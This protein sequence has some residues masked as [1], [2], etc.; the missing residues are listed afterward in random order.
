MI[1][2][3]F[4]TIVFG[5]SQTPKDLEW[6][7][8]KVL[9]EKLEDPHLLAVDDKFLYFVTGGHLASLKAGTSGVWKISI[10]GG[11]PIQLFKGYQKDEKTV[12]LPD[13]FVLAIDKEYVYFAAG[14]IYRI[15]KEGGEPEQITAGTPT[16]MV[17]DEENIYWHNFVGE[18]M[19]PT[20]VYSVS[21][22]GGEVKT[23]TDA[24]RVIDIAVD[25]EGFYWAQMDGIYKIG[26]KS[27]EKIRVYKAANGSRIT[28]MIIDKDSILLVENN[29]LF[30]IPKTGG[31]AKIITP[32]INSV[33]KFFVD[34]RNVYFVI[35]EGS[36]GTSLNKVSKSGGEVTKIDSGYFNQ[37]LIGKDKIY[38]SDKARIYELAK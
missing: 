29:Q 28:G 26:K 15:S 1:L 19:P 37:Y 23:L 4:L 30:E 11:Q 25:Q 22:K 18:S 34:E 12:F 36:F 38:I 20:P 6:T 13:T 31:N 21:K 17:L 24:V 7:N 16:E 10:E 14:Y 35:N 27:G 2:T 33:H 5:C 8:A 32:N 9:T 3:I